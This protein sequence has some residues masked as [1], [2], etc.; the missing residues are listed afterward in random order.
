MNQSQLINAIHE[1]ANGSLTKTV[2][3]RVLIALANVAQE[4]LANGDEV[5]I[6]GVAKLTVKERAAR[7][8]RNPQT[9]ETVEIP[10]KRVARASFVKALKERVQGGA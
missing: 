8:G 3:Q 7:T 10:A 5:T 2:I 6:P 1:D 4:A 9:G